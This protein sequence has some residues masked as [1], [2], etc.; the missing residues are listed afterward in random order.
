MTSL[1]RRVG[2]AQQQSLSSYN[3][4]VTYESAWI[5]DTLPVHLEPFVFVDSHYH[6]DLILK[7]LHFNTF[8]HMSSQISPAEHNKTFYYGV[9]HYVFP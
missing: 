3:K 6:L 5:L 4:F 2:P 9:A 8:L 7:R 1:L